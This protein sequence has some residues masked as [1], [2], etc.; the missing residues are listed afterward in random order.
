MVEHNILPRPIPNAATPDGLP[1]DGIGRA[2]QLLEL[3][4]SAWT[5]QL[6]YVAAEL[7][8]ADVTIRCRARTLGRPLMSASG[9]SR[10]FTRTLQFGR[11]RRHSGHGANPA[12]HPGDVNDP[13]QTSFSGAVANRFEVRATGQVSGIRSR[14]SIRRRVET[15][16]T[17]IA[18]RR[19]MRVRCVQAPSAS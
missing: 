12:A 7:G 4:N 9:T 2:S 11:N 3:I 16:A 5:S 14:S 17:S 13:K 15:T 19:V 10:Q 8:I 6:V 18:A 1:Q